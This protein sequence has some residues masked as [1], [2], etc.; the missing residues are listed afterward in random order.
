M[1]R[2]F[3]CLYRDRHVYT[4]TSV[5]HIFTN[6]WPSAHVCTYVH[7]E[8]PCCMYLLCLLCGFRAVC[9]SRWACSLQPSEVS[10]ARLAQIGGL[11][12]RLA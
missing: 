2:M 12:S 9:V 11:S 5:M 3:T 7:S 4:S 8:G 10:W 6:A 1:V